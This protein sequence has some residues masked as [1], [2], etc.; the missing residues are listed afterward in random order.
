MK[1]FELVAI[2][3]KYPNFNVYTESGRIELMDNWGVA[4]SISTD[5]E[6]D[7]DEY[8]DSSLVGLT[9]ADLC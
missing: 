5:D 2:L 4:V 3:N 7:D 6:E 9:E 1:A 8:Y